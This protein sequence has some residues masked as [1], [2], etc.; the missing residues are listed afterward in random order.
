[1]R[2]TSDEGRSY[3]DVLTGI[4]ISVAIASVVG[5][6]LVGSVSAISSDGKPNLTKTSGVLCDCVNSGSDITY[7]ICY[8]N[9]ASFGFTEVVLIDTLPENT[10]FKS[11]S[12]NGIN[13]SATHTVTWNIGTLTAGT[14]ETCVTVTV[15]VNPG[16][17]GSIINNT[18][19]LN[20]TYN[21]KHTI[22]TT[23]NE[24]EICYTHIPEFATIALPVA[25]ILGL[26]LFFNYRKRSNQSPVE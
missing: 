8:N 5:M 3:R 23:F 22:K 19:T 25:S 14:P 18:A 20:Y 6:L 1:M 7:T 11:A 9:S 16:T 26:F 2:I 21:D 4:A 10:T 17:S 13:D 24:T 15:T 12:D